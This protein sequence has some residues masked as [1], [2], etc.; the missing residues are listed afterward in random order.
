MADLSLRLEGAVARVVIDRPGKRNAM[1]LAMWRELPSLF[2]QAGQAKEVRV[3]VLQG[4]NA[5]AF[6]AGADIGELV[7][8]AASEQLAGA[9]MDT[10]EAATVAMTSC[11]K[12]IVAA[13]SGDC[14]GG[15]V[16][17]AMACDVRLA[18]RASRFA[19]P[20][21]RL[22]ALYGFS[23]TRRL[24]NLVGPGRAK[25]LLFSGRQFDAEEAYA[26]GLLDQLHVAEAF[27]AAVEQYVAMLCQRARSSQ[28]GA[29]TMV[30]AALGPLESE[31]ATLRRLR[32]DNLL[33]E[34]LKE[35]ASAFLE[36]RLASF[37]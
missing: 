27:D 10:I 30:A 22:G 33:G 11:P 17:L 21:A 14:M 25:D 2:A 24:V 18:S 9:F 19:V 28:S 32:L 20:P 15:G 7:A 13:I 5:E 8:H 36:K 3:I 29:K 31:D 12:P 34:D 4:A 35:G 26:I 6:S 16:E 37:R 1:S 23:S